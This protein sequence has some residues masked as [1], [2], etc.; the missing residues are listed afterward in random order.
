MQYRYK[1]YHCQSL[2]LSMSENQR[3]WKENKS[4][5]D[6]RTKIHVEDILKTIKSKD[7]TTA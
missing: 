3:K 2:S 4:T 5:E 7:P 1:L 6:E